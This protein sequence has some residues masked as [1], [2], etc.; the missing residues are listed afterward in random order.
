MPTK[1]RTRL[2]KGNPNRAVLFDPVLSKPIGKRTQKKRP[3]YQALDQIQGLANI[4]ANASPAHL[5]NRLNPTEYRVPPHIELMSYEIARCMS[6]SRRLLIHAPVRHGKSELVSH[7]TPLWWL[8]LRP[9]DD[10][11]IVSHGSDF[12]K[13]WGRRVR[14]TI[15]ENPHLKLHIRAD[16]SAQGSWELENGGSLHTAGIGGS[17]TG[18]GFN[19]IIVDDPFKNDIE[20]YSQFQRERVWNWFS[21]TLM[22]RLHPRGSVIIIMSRWHQDDLAG[23]LIDGWGENYDRIHLP[24]IYDLPVDPDEELIPDPLGRKPGEALWPY[25][26]PVD[27]LMKHKT[28]V[29]SIIWQAQYQ[30]DP[31]PPDGNVFKREWWKFLD[32][33][34]IPEGLVDVRGYDFG[35][36]EDGDPTASTLMRRAMDGRIIILDQDQYWMTPGMRNRRIQLVAAI[37]GITTRIGIP[38]DPGAAGTSVVDDFMREVLPE[39]IVM[40]SPESGDKATRAFSYAAQVEAGNVYLVRGAWNKGYIDELADFTPDGTVGKHDDQVDSSS[41]AYNTLARVKIGGMMD[42]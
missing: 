8:N 11:A 2:H 28:A 32:T 37:D 7:A 6:K 38:D 3:E 35:A 22:T 33:S 14:D 15:N 36:T 29:G 26:W 20:A 10:V 40:S 12:A 16:V 24:A 39:Y 18:R 25:M 21:R 17:I 34:E 13:L 27:E 4:L 5:M 30:G 9:K 41:R 1:T 19:L 31:R 42:L 23:R